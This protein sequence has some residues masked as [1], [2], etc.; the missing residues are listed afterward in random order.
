MFYIESKIECKIM[1]VAKKCVLFMVKLG[2]VVLCKSLRLSCGGTVP[3]DPCLF[4]LG[5][6]IKNFLSP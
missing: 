1:L 5:K 2:L 4:G 3:T 6:I